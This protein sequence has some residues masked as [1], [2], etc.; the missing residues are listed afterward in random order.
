VIL[1]DTHVLIY[2]LFNPARLGSQTRQAIG[3]EWPLGN[4]AVSAITF[5]EVAMLH[6][7]GRLTLLQDIESWRTSLLNDGLIEIPVD[8]AIGIK[9]NS[10]TDF[11]A[12]PADRIIVATALQG[13]QLVSEDRLILDWPG[14][15]HR[16][17][18]TA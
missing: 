4:V 9:A 12:D 7:K 6:D 18:A 5:W 17:R 11:H 1:L 8:G 15:L 3:T 13:H 2:L 14:P 10:L 16:L